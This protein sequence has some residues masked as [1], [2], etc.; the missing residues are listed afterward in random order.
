MSVGMGVLMLVQ[1]IGQFFGSLIPASLLGPD[2][3]NWALCAVVLSAL[4][5][6]GTVSILACRF[7]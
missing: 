6:G 3:S 4:G 1:S 2:I 5:L 7:K